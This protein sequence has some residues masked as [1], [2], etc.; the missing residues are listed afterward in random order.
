M[1]TIILTKIAK[2]TLIGSLSAFLAFVGK[3]N[4][5][6]H[7]FFLYLYAGTLALILIAALWEGRDL[8]KTDSPEDAIGSLLPALGTKKQKRQYLLAPTVRL[9]LA[10][11]IIIVTMAALVGG[12]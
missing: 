8:I 6:L 2:F 9:E 10:I 4:P 3:F 7:R 5:N 11:S 1:N 12:I